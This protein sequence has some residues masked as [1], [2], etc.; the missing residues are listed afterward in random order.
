LTVEQT[1][2]AKP[3]EP[4]RLDDFACQLLEN[5]ECGRNLFLM[6]LQAPVGFQCEPGQFVMLDLPTP[7]F[8]FR[9]PFSLLRVLENQQ[10][11][12][13]YK[14]VGKGTRQMAALQ[15]GQML[16]VL[17]P[18]GKPFPES[19]QHQKTLMIGGG[20]GIAPLFFVADVAKRGQCGQE[21]L[22]CVYGVQTQADFGIQAELQALLP[23]AQLTFCTDDGSFGFCGNVLDWLKANQATLSEVEQVFVCG[24][25][26]MMEAVVQYFEQQYFER[27]G[28]NAP[29]VYVSLESHMPC[30]TGAC[31]GCVVERPGGQLPVKTCLEGPVFEASTL[32]W[33]WQKAD[34]AVWG[35][36]CPA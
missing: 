4:R 7:A 14:V 36:V 9:R 35:A 13:L 2:Q 18:L 16:N 12:I 21:H 25:Q 31:T 6:R 5:L 32:L 10:F 29:T 26:K 24:P 19:W 33:P 17:A 3:C 8:M 1:N 22:T 23:E 20:I 30:G 28:D 11:E 15:T 27:L 34:P